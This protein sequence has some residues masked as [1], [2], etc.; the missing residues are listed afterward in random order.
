MLP[1]LTHPI[2]A[3]ISI[4][5]S[6]I[7]TACSGSAKLDNEH[8][9]AEKTKWEYS[10]ICSEFDFTGDVEQDKEGRVAC[11]KAADF[12]IAGAQIL[13]ALNDLS[14]NRPSILHDRE[15]ALEYLRRAIAQ[16]NPVAEMYYGLWLL[17]TGTGP[18]E[19]TLEYL[20]K[21]YCKE[22]MDIRDILE[23][24][25]V[26]V[27]KFNCDSFVEENTID[28]V[29]EGTF[30][31][32]LDGLATYFNTENSNRELRLVLNHP[33]A[34]VFYKLEGEWVPM[35]PGLF[36]F[37]KRDLHFSVEATESGWTQGGKWIET[38]SMKLSRLEEDR[39]FVAYNRLVT[40]QHA[41]DDSPIRFYT[42][43]GEGYL[44]KM[45]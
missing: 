16:G 5:L 43:M 4:L 23:R 22:V 7:L 29:W 30:R 26:D 21:A 1:K 11:M 18:T 37:E 36:I 13:L 42:Q 32:A 10:Q 33:N 2:S 14:P 20:E 12:G 6:L 27:S 25:G 8:Q 35:K 40:N 44:S 39:L 45:P 3:C 34:Q 17:R 38:V 28:G 15:L 41:L 24:D 19:E 9:S 31:L